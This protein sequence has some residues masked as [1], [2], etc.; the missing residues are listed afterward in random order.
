LKK[1]FWVYILIAIVI[2]LGLF[3]YG[4]FSGY[5]PITNLFPQPT[6][7]PTPAPSPTPTEKPIEPSKFGQKVDAP[8]TLPK[9]LSVMDIYLHRH[10]DGNYYP[11]DGF[12]LVASAEISSYGI[13]DYAS[14][15]DTTS[16]TFRTDGKSSFYLKSKNKAAE[17]KIK[18]YINR[19]SSQT[20]EYENWN[21]ISAFYNGFVSVATTNGGQKPLETLNLDIRT[22][23]EFDLR[24]FFADNVDAQKELNKF[25]SLY[26][27]STH[28]EDMYKFK[29]IDM[30]T[31]F[32]IDLE[33][34]D[35]ILFPNEKT[36]PLA[37]E[38]IRI[39]FYV[40]GNNGDVIAIFNRFPALKAEEFDLAAW[41]KDVAPYSIEDEAN[42]R[43]S[44]GYWQEAQINI[45]KQNMKDTLNKMKFSDIIQKQ[46]F[47]VSE[48]LYTQK[49]M[50]DNNNSMP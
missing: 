13:W 34:N 1:K 15:T 40:L 23:E 17:T 2:L 28:E 42:N 29:G 27:M 33:Q 39:P 18:D 36:P 25:L 10:D 21:D 44:G 6:L 45:W 8:V 19:N 43:L 46:N 22:G 41:K 7:A 31:P 35:L 30:S 47:D 4:Y 14:E 3:A 32:Y 49:Q 48:K 12:D 37:G 9:S 20:N 5:K 16:Q 50:Q 26:L 38:E 24:A 11:A